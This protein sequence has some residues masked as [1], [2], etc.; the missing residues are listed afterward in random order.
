MLNYKIQ[1]NST[2]IAKNFKNEA[3]LFINILFFNNIL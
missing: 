3:F 2:F 1:K